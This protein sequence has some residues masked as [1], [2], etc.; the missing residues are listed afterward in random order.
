MM[1][2]VARNKFTRIYTAG[3]TYENRDLF[4]FEFNTGK[5]ERNLWLDCGIHAREW[6][7]ISTCIWIIER[8]SS[9][10]NKKF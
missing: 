7:S 10:F 3:K 2:T 1:L 4:V 9:R 6:V 5:T 8:V